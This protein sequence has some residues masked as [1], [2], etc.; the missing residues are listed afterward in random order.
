M[1]IRDRVKVRFENYLFKKM[2][3]EFLTISKSFNFSQF[4]SDRLE[5]MSA[6]RNI[7]SLHRSTC[8]SSTVMFDALFHTRV[9]S[10]ASHRTVTIFNY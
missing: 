3:E 9:L 4:Q 1:I 10:A 5:Q 6:H 2:K 8:P 7:D